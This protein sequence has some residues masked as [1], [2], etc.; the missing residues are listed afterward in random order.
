MNAAMLTATDAERL[1]ERVSG[2]GVAIF[3]TDTV[4]GICCDPDNEAA[5]RR[6]YELKGYPRARQVERPAAVMFF[7]LELALDALR[8]LEDAE[9]AAVETLLPGPV[10]LLLP[11]RARRFAPACGP[12]PDTVGLRVPRLPPTLAALHSLDVPVMQSSANLS[13]GPDARA[14]VEVP[15][16]IRERADLVLDG[17]ELPGAAST[18]IDLRSY[19]STGKWRVARVGALA[20][21]AIQRALSSGRS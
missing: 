13:G 1:Q 14:L 9:R 4:Y 17:G 16:S 7:A 21:A 2:G 20:V 8:D 11:N 19:A 6:L 18:V 15:V 12:D 10:T 5:V 3:P